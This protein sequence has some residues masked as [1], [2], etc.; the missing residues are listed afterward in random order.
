LAMP[1]TLI[2]RKFRPCCCLRGLVPMLVLAAPLRC[3][4]STG[5]EE[6]VWHNNALEAAR[7]AKR[8]LSEVLILA[9]LKFSLDA[10]I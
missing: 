8:E 6:A 9:E 3:F 10:L 2:V 5:N 1:C 7:L 4:S